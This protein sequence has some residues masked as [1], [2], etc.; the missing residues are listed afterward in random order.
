MVMLFLAVFLLVLA[1]SRYWRTVLAVLLALL[2][3]LAVVGV[4]AVAAEATPPGQQPGTE[5]GGPPR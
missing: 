5:Q 4:M 1:M 3:A 2:V